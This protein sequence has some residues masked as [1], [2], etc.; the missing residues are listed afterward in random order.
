[1]GD[2]KL[3]WYIYVVWHVWNCN[4]RRY[5]YIHFSFPFEFRSHSILYYKWFYFPQEWACD[6]I[7]IGNFTW[8]LFSTFTTVYRHQR[9]SD[10]EYLP[11]AVSP[12]GYKC[13]SRRNIWHYYNFP[14]FFFCNSIINCEKLNSKLYQTLFPRNGRICHWH[15]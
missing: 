7:I 2:L 13:M 3:F 6:V 5:L 4:S 8:L 12:K 15:F 1:M 10:I 9:A 11:M 14:L